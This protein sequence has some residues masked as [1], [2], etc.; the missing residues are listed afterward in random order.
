[1]V[2]RQ[3]DLDALTKSLSAR[4]RS[5]AAPQL[6]EN[7]LTKTA[8]V[9]SRRQRVI[10]QLADIN[11]YIDKLPVDRQDIVDRLGQE[12]SVGPAFDWILKE[13]QARALLGASG[14]WAKFFGAI[15]L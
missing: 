3:I 7:Q 2:Q 1:M 9:A 13:S 10:D 8:A 6:A 15:G 11:E 12:F 5:A 4:I 14:Y